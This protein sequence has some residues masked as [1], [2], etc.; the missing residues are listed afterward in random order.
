MRV[1]SILVRV[2][3]FRRLAVEM[4][5]RE[6]RSRYAGSVL[7]GAWAILEPALQFGLYVL[8]FAYFAGTSFVGGAGV[9]GYVLH[10]V[11]GMVPFLAFQE[12]LS[13]ASGLARA[14]AALVRHVNVPIEVLLTGSLLAIAGR[15]AVAMALVVTGAALTGALAWS[16]MGWMLP[17]VLVLGALCWGV[18]LAL[19]PAGAFMPD[20]GQVV[21]SVTSVLFFLTPIVYYADKLPPRAARYVGLNPLTGAIDLFRAAVTGSGLSGFR[22]AITLVVTVFAVWMGSGIFARH[23]ET[24]RDI[25]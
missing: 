8:V 17:A 7:G 23:A 22:L 19:V 18:T 10:L 25:V 24:I 12:C 20:V 1:I 16:Q 14:N 15:Y 4:G 11:T 13:R 3:R 5:R 21:V 6:F 2:W 9:S